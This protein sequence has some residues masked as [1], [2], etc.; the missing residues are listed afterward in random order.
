MRLPALLAALLF[1]A[2]PA[3]ADDAAMNAQ[4]DAVLGDHAQYRAFF[5]ELQTRVANRDAEAV[6]AM[7]AYPITVRTNGE[8]YLIPD[9]ESFAAD[10]DSLITPAVAD[11]IAAQA[12][13]TLFVNADGMMIGNGEVWINGTCAT[14]SC[15]TFDPMI[16]T[17]QEVN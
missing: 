7:I 14:E 9:A 6:S 3:I 12:W 10:Y 16:V 8:E 13:D 2:L 17:I 5:D 1:T 11:A 15:E 4:V